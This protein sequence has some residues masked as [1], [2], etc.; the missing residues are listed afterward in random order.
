VEGEVQKVGDHVRINAQ[1]ID[2]RTDEH[3]WAEQYN[4]ELTDVFAIQ[5]EVAQQIAAALMATLTPAEKQHIERRPTDNLVAYDYYSRARHEYYKYTLEG[6]ASAIALFEE[7]LEQDE[8][9]AMALAGLSL[10]QSQY[11][12]R[13]WSDDEEWLVKAEF[14]AR[15]A[16]AIDPELIEAHFAL[17]FVHERRDNTEEAE[18]EMKVVL[19][20]NPNHA[21]AHDSLG[22]VYFRRGWLERA[23]AE[24]EIALRLDPFLVP[25][26]YLIGIVLRQKGQY[27]GALRHYQSALRANPDIEWFH[28]GIGDVLR[29]KGD[30]SAAVESYEAALSIAPH[31][32]AF[33]GL[34]RSLIALHDFA[35]ARSVA[36][37]LLGVAPERASM[38]AGY[39]YILG[40]MDLARGD[41]ESAIARF[42]EAAERQPSSFYRITGQE[43]QARVALAEANVAKGAA[44]MAARQLEELLEN[45]PDMLILRYHLGIAQEAAG[46]TSKAIA[47]FRAFLDSWKDADRDAPALIDTR[48]RLAALVS[49][50]V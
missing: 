15:K 27:E 34:A 31:P 45:Y 9:F 14:S 19:E 12:N 39:R 22:D 3:I 20:G 46:D 21:H 10:C 30:H 49:S 4:R 43:H 6:N 38:K 48:R 44:R 37:R 28:I 17:G 24:Y 7:A 41:T 36:E 11:I 13:G 26:L 35:G 8:T 2:A 25:S 5:S 40:H 16:L 50:E 23:L 18:R 33:L 1:L 42:H 47:E 32:D 29:D